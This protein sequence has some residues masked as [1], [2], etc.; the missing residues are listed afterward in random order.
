MKHIHTARLGGSINT[1]PILGPVKAPAIGPATGL[2]GPGTKITGRLHVGKCRAAAG[3]PIRQM[4]AAMNAVGRLSLA[5]QMRARGGGGGACAQWLPGQSMAACR[6]WQ[7]S[8]Q[9]CGDADLAACARIKGPLTPT[10]IVH[11]PSA[12]CPT[13]APEI[14]RA[15]WHHARSSRAR[16]AR[17]GRTALLS[18]QRPIRSHCARRLGPHYMPA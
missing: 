18:L 9:S 16:S 3:L 6:L 1:P 5:V 7:S 14:K 8:D 11:H 15:A 13:A 4:V 12:K 10:T 2:I 17:S